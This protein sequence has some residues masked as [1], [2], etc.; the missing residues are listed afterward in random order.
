[1]MKFISKDI[2]KLSILYL[3]EFPPGS[4]ALSV[5]RVVVPK[6][7]DIRIIPEVSI[8]KEGFIPPIL[9]RQS[10]K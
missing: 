7:M 10:I 6:R 5:V 8:K 3:K 4:K 2:K 1:M 9:D